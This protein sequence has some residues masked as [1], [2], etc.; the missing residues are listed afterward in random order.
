MPDASTPPEKSRSAPARRQA[1]V[2][3]LAWGWVVLLALAAIAELGGFADLRLALDV[4]R[5]FNQR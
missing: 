4:Q 5:H 1:W 3:Y 2:P